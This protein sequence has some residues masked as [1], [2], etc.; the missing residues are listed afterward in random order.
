MIKMKNDVY[1]EQKVSELKIKFFTNV[2]HELRTPLTLIKG[3]I[4]ELKENENLSEK[5]AKYITLMEKNT[6]HMLG[7]VNQILDFRKIQ[8]KKMRLHISPVRLNTLI[9]SFYNEFYLISMETNISYDYHLL[10]D[11]IVVWVDKE[12]LETVI[13]NIISN[14]FK[15]LLPVEVF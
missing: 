10:G 6:N 8:N 7:L 1:I 15:L 13:R 9:E 3:P 11:N 2:S 14:A 12:K 4:Q 5:G